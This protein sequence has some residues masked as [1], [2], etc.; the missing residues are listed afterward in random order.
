MLI[1]AMKHQEKQDY[2]E[3]LWISYWRVT[4]SI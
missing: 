4:H 2:L 3:P 1:I